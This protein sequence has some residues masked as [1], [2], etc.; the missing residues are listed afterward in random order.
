MGEKRIVEAVAK[1]FAGARVDKERGVIVNAVLCGRRSQNGRTYS[2]ESFRRGIGHYQ[3]ALLG[4]DHDLKGPSKVESI[5]GRVKNARVGPDGLPRGDLHLLKSHPLT[6]RILE[7]AERE[8]D[9]GAPFCYGLSHVASCSTS[10]SKSG[11]ET[12]EAINSV[13]RLDF[14][15]QPATVKGIFSEAKREGSGSGRMTL[16]LLCER[17][18]RSGKSGLGAIHRARRVREAIDCGDLG[19]VGLD[20]AGDVDDAMSAPQITDILRNGVDEA[21]AVIVQQILDDPANAADLIDQLEKL[22][23]SY[24]DQLATLGTDTASES[25]HRATTDSRSFAEII[26]GRDRAAGKAFAEAIRS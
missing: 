22:V 13:G 19:D 5:I 4:V 25:R 9:G 26:T 7:A 6:P 1:P 3:N 17:I 24:R 15:A 20:D 18:E 10:R 16:H 21:A 8:L 12:V 23:A 2:L 11:E 14:V